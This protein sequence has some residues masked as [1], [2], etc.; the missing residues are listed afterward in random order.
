MYRW[1]LGA[2]HP[3]H[4]AAACVWVPLARVREEA[5]THQWSCVG[6]LC[7]SQKS[8][9]AL[10]P[11]AAAMLMNFSLFSIQKHYIAPVAPDFRSRR[12]AAQGDSAH[13]LAQGPKA[14][15]WNS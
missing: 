15:Q 6:T 1:S 2:F 11:K 8:G 4:G 3:A 7:V 9:E 12:Q 13:F 14:L 5:E 10:L